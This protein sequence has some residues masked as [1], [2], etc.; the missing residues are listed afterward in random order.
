MEA[1]GAEPLPGAA[2]GPEATAATPRPGLGPSPPSQ[3]SPG[4]TLRPFI[5]VR[6]VGGFLQTNLGNLA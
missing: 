2:P 1:A 4:L 5:P 6:A 3:L